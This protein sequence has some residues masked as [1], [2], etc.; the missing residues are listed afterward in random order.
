MTVAPH[1]LISAMQAF[2]LLQKRNMG[3]LVYVTYS[4]ARNIDLEQIPVVR[5]CPDVFLDELTGL[6]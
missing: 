4:K 1:N 5:V 3:Y 2:K 6:P